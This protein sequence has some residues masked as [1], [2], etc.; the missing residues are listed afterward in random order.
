MAHSRTRRL[1]LW[2]GVPVVLIALLVAFWNWDWFIPL[3]DARASAAIGRPVRIAHLHIGLGGTVTA[4]ADDVVVAN[5]KGW[6]SQDPPFA[7][8]KR[9]TVRVQLLRWIEGH[10]LVI[11]LIALEQP[12]MYVAEQPNGAANFRLAMKSGGKGGSTPQIGNLEITDGNVRFIIPKLK[13]NFDAAV[14]TKGEGADAKLLVNARGTY[15]AQPIDARFIGGALLSLRDASNPWPVDLTV[16]NGQT[17]VALRGTVRDPM[18]FKG[19]DLTLRVSGPNLGQLEPLTGFP[20]PN[21]PAYQLSGKL[22]LQGFDHISFQDFRGRLGESDLEGSIQEEPGAAQAHGKSKPVVTMNLASRRVN[23]NDLA[24][25]IG[26]AP[27]SAHEAN[28]TPQQRAA[29]ER[30]AKSKS[31][32]PNTPIS[33][34]RLNWADIHLRYRGAHIEGRDIPLD[35]VD[36]ALDVVN[37]QITLHPLSFG[38]GTGRLIADLDL[39]PLSDR[40]VRA[41]MDLRMQNLD[42]SRLMAATHTFQGAG[43]I[44]GVGA[45][46]ATGDSLASLLGHGNGEV[47]MAMAGG[48]LSAVLVDLTGLEFGNALLSALG[49]PQKTQVQCFVGDLALQE[50]VLDFRALELDTKETLTNV[51]GAVN[52]ARETIDLHLRTQAKHFSIGSLPTNINITGTFKSPTIRPGAAVA[53]RAGAAVGLG[54]LFAPLAI[55]PT[56]QFGTSKAQDERCGALLQQARAGAGGKV[57]PPAPAAEAAHVK[58]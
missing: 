21:T 14:A 31:L 54:V 39:V 1:A 49:M 28:A 11:P 9:L 45:I 47:K 6:P 32:L 24:G 33:V 50:G 26:G 30:A 53:A 19:A 10:G 8:I 4:S 3:V 25:F 34:P 22:G 42:V 5:P 36:V 20:I 16:A 56:I 37:G 43:A 55:L 17:H 46:D 18:A 38:V 40:N 41:K 29:A 44:S 7:A 35:N 27:G 51:S 2:I 13:A 15:A 58:R 23:L 12:R 52:L 48:D 57:L